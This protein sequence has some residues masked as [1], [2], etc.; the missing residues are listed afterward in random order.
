MRGCLARHA[1]TNVQ[2]GKINTNVAL[3]PPK[4]SEISRQSFLTPSSVLQALFHFCLFL[5]TA[6]CIGG[7][8]WKLRSC[9]V[10]W[11]FISS[12]CWAC[13]RLHIRK[14]THSH[15]RVC[16]YNP[17]CRTIRIRSVA[18]PLLGWTFSCDCVASIFQVRFCF[19]PLLHVPPPPFSCL[20]L[21]LSVDSPLR[22]PVPEQ[23]SKFKR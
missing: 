2:T 8:T 12:Q 3:I 13:V 4:L 19:S 21:L 10:D 16:R 17:V 1:Y 11:F 6:G 5:F 22:D 9:W 18:E 15:T 20:A 23:A 7:F 14:H